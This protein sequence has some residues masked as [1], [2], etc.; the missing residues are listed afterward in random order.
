MG[1]LPGR[2]IFTLLG[3]SELKGRQQIKLR[4]YWS[5]E[6]PTAEKMA[7]LESPDKKSVIYTPISKAAPSSVL[8]P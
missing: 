5:E 3:L 1:T 7:R 6:I 2:R 4:N 8:R